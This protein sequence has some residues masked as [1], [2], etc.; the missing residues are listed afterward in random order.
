MRCD[1]RLS[2]SIWRYYCRLARIPEAIQKG[3]FSHSLTAA[4]RERPGARWN[5]S[6]GRMMRHRC[7]IGFLMRNQRGSAANAVS[8]GICGLLCEAGLAIVTG[9]LIVSVPCAAQQLTN[10]KL[11]LTIN[12]QDGSYQLEVRAASPCSPAVWQRRLITSGCA[13]GST[14]AIKLP[15]LHSRM[16]SARGA[17]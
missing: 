17:W 7:S 1:G 3:A 15:N 12:A 4:R 11:S 13:R 8:K 14:R 6:C 16:N 5:G 9:A 10:D 2:G